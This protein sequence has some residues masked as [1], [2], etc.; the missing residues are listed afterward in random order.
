MR[1]WITF[2]FWA[3]IVCTLAGPGLAQPKDVIYDE[4][5]VPSYVLPDPLVMQD[6]TKVADAEAWTSRR[7]PEILHLFEEHVYGRSAERPEEIAFSVTSLDASALGGKATRKELTVFLTGKRDGLKMELLLYAPNAVNKPVPTFLGL[8]F[9]GNHGVSSDPG[10]ALSKQW[11][12]PNSQMGVVDNRA[13]EASRGCTAHRW[14]VE[15]VLDP[16]H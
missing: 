16:R 8:N 1:R 13:T 9:Y 2:W 12:R 11:M 10:I 3:A 4:A 7:R 6:G 15:K 5:Q 14:Q